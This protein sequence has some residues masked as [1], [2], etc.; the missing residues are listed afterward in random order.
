MA[1]EEEGIPPVK[2]EE[3]EGGSLEPTPR[4]GNFSLDGVSA[5]AN[6]DTSD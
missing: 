2:V 5:S 6:A 3:V 4:G 1:E